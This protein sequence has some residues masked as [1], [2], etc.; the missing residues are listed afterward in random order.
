MIKSLTVENF[1]SI[2]K[3]DIEFG[4][5][6]VLIG[7][8]GSGK[9]N[10][11]EAIALAGAAAADK[12]D[13]EFLASRGIRVTNPEVMRAAFSTENISKNI[14]FKIS[15]DNEFAISFA[16]KNSNEP[17]STWG[18]TS[19]VVAN[20]TAE[21][22]D[23]VGTLILENFKQQ[24]WAFWESL[25]KA[26]KVK[27]TDA[28]DHLLD[29]IISPNTRKV[30]FSDPN[31][32]PIRD[33]LIYAPEN[34]ALRKFEEEGQI[35]PLGIRGEGL[36][37]L[38]GVL[39]KDTEAFP[40]IKTGLQVLG[41]FKDFKLSDS[42]HPDRKIQLE[43]KYLPPEIN[44]LDQKSA[45]EGFLFLLF[46]LALFTSK[47]TPKFFAID[48]IEAS[49]NP[50]LCEKLMQELTQLAKQ[51][52]KQVI[53]TT[54]NPSILDGLNLDDPEQILYVVNR[55]P[56]GYTKLKRIQKPKAIADTKP[57]K[58]SAAFLNGYLGGLPKGF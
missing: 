38:L 52:D 44:L 8:N 2:D 41:W 46:Y 4:R 37:K 47:N 39:S 55:T 33:F 19:K 11:L 32:H 14:P 16:L 45:N 15:T 28:L 35:Q 21:E 27:N 50:K 10:I 29:K 5:V 22:K 6:T 20:L 54:H 42:N 3:L 58:L 36:F 17:Y 56:D 24:N 30:I 12:L 7:E 26:T 9:S 57:T 1:K 18:V 48:N 31:I 23:K 34:S 51:F 53:F 49:F 40:A 43:D 25:Q 13:N